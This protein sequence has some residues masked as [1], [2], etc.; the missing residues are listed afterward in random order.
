MGNITYKAVYRDPAQNPFKARLTNPIKIVEIDES[1]P[2]EEVK[3]MAEEAREN[4]EFVR[5]ERR[6]KITGEF[7]LVP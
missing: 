7:E 5:L 2:T 3:E 1:T 6:S 4:Y